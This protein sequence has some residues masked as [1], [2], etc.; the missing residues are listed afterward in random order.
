MTLLAM[1]HPMHVSSR[2][3]ARVVRMRAREPGID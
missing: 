1:F 2:V 3:H